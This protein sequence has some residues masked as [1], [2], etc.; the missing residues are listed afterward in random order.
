MCLDIRRVSEEG[1]WSLGRWGLTGPGG[2]AAGH[3]QDTLLHVLLGVLRPPH[4]PEQQ[5]LHLHDGDNNAGPGDG[6]ER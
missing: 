1:P 4:L 5:F 2:Q 3:T 6:G